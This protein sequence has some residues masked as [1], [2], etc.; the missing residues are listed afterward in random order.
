[1]LCKRV[2]LYKTLYAT[3]ID[4]RNMIFV[5][6]WIE[7]EPE[8]S[9][10]HKWY[11]HLSNLTALVACSACALLRPNTENCTM[12]R[13]ISWLIL[14]KFSLKT[15]RKRKKKKGFIAKSAVLEMWSARSWQELNQ[16][17]RD[18][19]KVVWHELLHNNCLSSHHSSWQ[20]V[21]AGECLPGDVGQSTLIC[22][23]QHRFGAVRK[24]KGSL[25]KAS[26]LQ[27]MA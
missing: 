16:Q 15:F 19:K 12:F 11:L 8:S 25:R 27:V 9:M 3:G 13:N 6:E 1:M 10:A 26:V 18:S 4:A 20:R 2:V 24:Q 5:L 23:W 14:Q 21:I 17:A 7:P 22:M